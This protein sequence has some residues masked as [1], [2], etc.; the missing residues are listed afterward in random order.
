[1]SIL[2][3]RN[4]SVLEDFGKPYIVAEVNTSHFGDI[5]VAKDMIDQVKESGCHCVKFQS[6]TADTLYSKTYYDENPMAKRFVV[7]FSFSEDELL[8]VARYSRERGLD[9]ASTPYSKKEVDFLLNE[10]NAPYIKVASMDLNNHTFLEYIGKTGAPIVLSTGMGSMDEI[11]KAVSVIEST[12]NTNICLLHCISI[13]PPDLS[14]IHLNNISALRENFP[15]YPVGFSDHSIGIEIPSAAVALGACMLE[16]HFTLDKSKIGMDN[17]VAT[18][19]KEMKEMVRSCNN[20]HSAM[21]GYERVV[22]PAEIEQ[23]KQMRRSIVSTRDLEPGDVLTMDDLDVKR[24]GIGISADKVCSL[25]GAVVARNIEKD[26]VIFEEDI[27]KR[28]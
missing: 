5:K 28:E 13:Y 19:P 24:P 15:N 11:S 17:Q 8:E 27:A 6:W 22:L 26:T 3:L 7:G 23:R 25:I 1:M 16:K 18:E 10:C 21:G 2:E 4:S 9:F 12:G 20:I 14:T